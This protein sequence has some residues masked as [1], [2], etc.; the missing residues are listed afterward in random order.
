MDFYVEQSEGHDDFVISLA[1]VCEG[2]ERLVGPAESVLVKPVRLYSK[3]SR[4]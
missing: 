1:L 2:L 4:Y 3:E